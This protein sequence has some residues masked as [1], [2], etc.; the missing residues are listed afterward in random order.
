MVTKENW[1][2]MAAEGP[3]PRSQGSHLAPLELPPPQK[4]RGEGHR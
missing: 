1:A 3:L 4:Q 2:R